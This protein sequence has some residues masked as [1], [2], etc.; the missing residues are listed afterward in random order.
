LGLPRTGH[1]T[2]PQGPILVTEIASGWKQRPAHSGPTWPRLLGQR[3]LTHFG[4]SGFRS[5]HSSYGV[6]SSLLRRAGT[7]RSL[8]CCLG[9]PAIPTHPSALRTRDPLTHIPRPHI[10]ISGNGCTLSRTDIPSIPNR[11]LS[12]PTG[13]RDIRAAG[14]PGK[15]LLSCGSSPPP[16][17]DGFKPNAIHFWPPPGFRRHVEISVGGGGGGKY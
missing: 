17:L 8:R 5:N 6:K 13:C 4:T 11:M 16:G 15:S 7:R 3:T 12:L 2:A 14:V 9:Q 1:V 10:F